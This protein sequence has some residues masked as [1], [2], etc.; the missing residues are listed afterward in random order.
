MALLAGIS[1]DGKVLNTIKEFKIKAKDF[2]HA[3]EGSMEIR[4]I[5]K[6]IDLDA[7][8]IQRVSICSYEAEMNVVMHGANGIISMIQD[9]TGVVVEVMDRGPGIDDINLAL[10]EG[11]TT[12]GEEVQQ[13]GFGAGMGLPNIIRNSDYFKI[14]SEKGKGTY[15]IMCFWFNN[16]IGKECRG[17]LFTTWD[18]NKHD[19]V[20]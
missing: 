18:N 8:I 3:G 6:S 4:N 1:Q 20:V 15:L 2:I 5:L 12:A 16:R 17:R 14:Y 11:F 19:G 9:E 10:T 7:D 13:M